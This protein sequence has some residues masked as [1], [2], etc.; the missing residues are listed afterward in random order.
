MTINHLINETSPY[1]KQHVNNPVDWYPWGEAA[2][3]K[4]RRENKPILLSIGYAACHWCHVMA[5]ESFEDTHTAEIMNKHFVNIKVDREERP[6][7]DKIY[8][9]AHYLLTQQNGGWPLTIFLSPKDLMPFFSGTYFPPQS[10]YQLPAFKTVLEKIATIYRDHANDIQTQSNELGQILAKQIAPV[11]ISHINQQP[12][13]LALQIF[14]GNF[15]PVNAGFGH[16]PKF[17]QS[18]KLAFLMQYHSAMFTETLK[19]IANGGIYDQLEGGFFRYSVDEKWEIPHFEKML[20]DN[21]QLLILYSL[22]A[23][24][25]QDPLFAEHAHLSAKWAMDV[26]QSD[27]GGFYSSLDADSEGHEGKFYVWEKSEVKNALSAEEYQLIEC[28]FGLN[29]PANFEGKWH[30]HIVDS[31]ESIANKLNIE[32]TQAINLLNSAKKKLSDVRSKRVAPACD[33][34]ILTSWNALMIKGMLTAGLFLQDPTYITSA[35]RAL[36]F[37]RKN[38][39]QHKRLLASYNDGKAHLSAYLDDYA[40]L[41]DAMITSLQVQWEQSHLEFAV[42]LA[43]ALLNLFSDEVNGGFY[44]TAHDHESL[45]YRPKAMMDEA[46]PAGN[47]IAARALIALGH[48]LG[49]SRYLLA[50]EKTLRVAWPMLA[51]YPAEHSSVLLALK[52]YLN[53]PKIIIIRAM[54]NELNDWQTQLKSLGHYV[55]AIPADQENLPTELAAKIYPGRSCAYICQG[56]HCLPPV[57][58]VEELKKQLN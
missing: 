2:I 45:L 16:A 36:N 37:I 48:M 56:M 52:D 21:A 10:R 35:H 49:E 23:Y 31:L 28:H 1:L 14:Q 34:K 15:D 24:S 54:P 12:I 33:N 42:E 7:L 4:A 17:P 20:Y 11:E 8:Q 32:S 5:H 43:E 3:E 44:F 19:H 39:W 58:S 22:A 50:A 47:G 53:P 46:I 26:M 6:D 57:Y 9:T 40:F 55:F 41:L 38:L 18:P 13:Q 29:L 51:R 30:L 27:E 25:Y